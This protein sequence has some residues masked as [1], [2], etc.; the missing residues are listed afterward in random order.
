MVGSVGSPLAVT[1]GCCQTTVT[2]GS[3]SALPFEHDAAV[4][5]RCVLVAGQVRSGRVLEDSTILR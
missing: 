5:N 2:E 1:I 3:V 4:A